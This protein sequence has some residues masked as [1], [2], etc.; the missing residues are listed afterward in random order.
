MNLCR[1]I[2][3]GLTAGGIVAIITVGVSIPL[4]SPNDLIFNS[5]SIGICVLILGGV[6]GLI[7]SWSSSENWLN[8][9]YIMSSLA[10]LVI[11]M[12]V[13]FGAQM[14]FDNAIRFTVPLALIAVPGT[15][16]LTPVINS[17]LNDRI[18][19]NA[20]FIVFAVT[21]SALTASHGDQESGIL[22][23]PPPP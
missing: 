18:W 6:N 5:A 20:M 21:V 1:T 11:A 23:L 16:V 22:S 19:L 15:I 2:Y 13:A 17:K 10:L 4:K 12:I 9:R 7:W 8:R 14:Q 3:L